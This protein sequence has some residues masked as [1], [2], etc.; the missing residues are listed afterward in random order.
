MKKI[1]QKSRKRVEK[2]EKLEQITKKLLRIIE[3]VV[4]IWPKWGNKLKKN[5]QKSRKN[6]GNWL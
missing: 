2:Y 6:V 4:K 3:N 5:D 1:D